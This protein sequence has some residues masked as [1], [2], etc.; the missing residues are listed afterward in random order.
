MAAMN[1]SLLTNDLAA[2]DAA[3]LAIA[4]RKAY[5]QNRIKECL[6]LIKQ[7]VL[8]DPHNMEAQSLQ[9]SRLSDGERDLSD[10]RILLSDAQSRE[11]GQKYRKAAEIILLKILHIDPTHTEA[12]ALMASAKGVAEPVH[13]PVSAPT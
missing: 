1:T 3:Q 2:M 4:A 5:E 6:R 13:V 9:A 10:A 8:A 11:N 7:L 12:K